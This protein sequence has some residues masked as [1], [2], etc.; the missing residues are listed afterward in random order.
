MIIGR[1][2]LY[3]DGDC[4]SIRT[5]CTDETTFWESIC[6]LLDE[7]IRVN[8]F[9]Y[10]WCF[11]LERW[12]PQV[13]DLA[14]MLRGRY[15]GH[16]DDLEL[17]AGGIQPDQNLVASWVNGV[18]AI[19]AAHTVP[20]GPLAPLATVLA[21]TVKP[22]AWAAATQTAGFP[23]VA[24]Q[25]RL[26]YVKECIT[27]A[28]RPDLAVGLSLNA[29]GY[30]ILTQEQRILREKGSVLLEEKQAAEIRAM[31]QACNFKRV[32]NGES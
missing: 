29:E 9:N 31:L 18:V 23:V 28:G 15:S 14:S 13:M 22:D 20:L 12:L 32:I 26:G 1:T 30:P 6:E 24:P 3:K 25:R 19:V 5:T 21:T 2:Q 4:M 10:D 27:A 11:Q 8:A 17:I 16:I 7:L